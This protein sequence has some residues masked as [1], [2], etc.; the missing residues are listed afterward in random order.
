MAKLAINGGKPVRKKPFPSWPQAGEREK[1]ELIRV[2]ESGTWGGYNKKVAEFEEKFAA[3]H[4]CR[5]GITST[6]GTITLVAALRACGVG[7]G[8]EVI[9]TPIS[10]IST[11]SA[12]LLA[13]AIPVFADIEPDTYNIDPDS[14]E[15]NLSPQTRAIIPVHFA[16]QP[17]NMDRIM[18]T[19]AK[20]NISV[21]E[22]A[23]HAHGAEWRNKRVGSFGDFGS[24]SFQNTKLL[25]CGEG[26]ALTTNSGDLGT[27]ARHYLNHGRRPDA[28]W[29]EHFFLGTNGRITGFQAA[30]L[31][32]QLKKL[33]SQNRL[34]TRNIAYLTKRLNAIG[35]LIPLSVRPEVTTPANYYLCCIYKP[36]IFGGLTREKFLD[37]LAAEG[38]R[39]PGF[40]PYPLNRNPLFA[41]P[42]LAS[43]GEPLSFAAPGRRFDYHHLP[44]PVAEQ[45]CREGA[46][47]AQEM[48]LG[49]KED[50]D[51]I[52]AA[53]EKIREYATAEL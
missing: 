19:A 17:C 42:K 5:F 41:D 47:F 36:E 53:V 8:D 13:G 9:V 43:S 32:E 31:L 12:V 15:K 52:A 38:I 20:R 39:R 35:G 22:D 37:A 3:A 4:H 1:K 40:Y 46:W 18:D 30:V 29:F 50:M 2:L 7:A 51:D 6:N 21:V 16:G 45:A 11:A 49:T 26:G 27:W 48:F 10:F 34:R 23:A 25:T 28:G 24:F 14:I 33:D 44:L